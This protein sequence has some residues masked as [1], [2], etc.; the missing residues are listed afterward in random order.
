MEKLDTANI[1]EIDRIRQILKNHP[2]LLSMFEIM[3][4]I[5]NNRI[6]QE[7]LSLSMEIEE[8]T[9]PELSDHESDEEEIF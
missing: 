1:I 3:V 8:N 2:D 4:I 7:P 6:N 5:A 9:E